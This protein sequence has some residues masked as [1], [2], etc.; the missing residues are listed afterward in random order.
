MNVNL[1]RNRVFVDMNNQV[2]MRSLAWALTQQNQ[3]PYK[4]R[5]IWGRAHSGDVAH[6][7]KPCEERDTQK[8]LLCEDGGK[9][10]SHAPQTK[11]HVWLPE[12]G[13]VRKDHLVEI[14]E[15]VQP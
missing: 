14:L 1:F 6:V 3:C 5:K 15:A 2:K 10:W 8:K 9:D 12:L 11:E 4:K 13:E 7:R